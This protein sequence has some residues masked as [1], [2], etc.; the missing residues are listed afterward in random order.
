VKN[1][2]ILITG[3]AGFLGREIISRT[4]EDNEITV[5]SR[6]EAK[7]YYLKRHYPRVRFVVGDVRDFDRLK[8]ACD[9]HTTAI[10]AASLKQIEA[11]DENPQE[12]SRTIIDGA[13]NSRKA[14]ED[15]SLK[16][17]CFISSDK[18]RA[19]TTVYGAM[20]Y[21][22]GESFI[23][24]AQE[25]PTRLTT[26]IYGNVLNSTGS[27]IPLIW[28]AIKNRR[29][30]NLYSTE[31]TRFLLT[32]EEAVSLV[33]TSL[34]S[35]VTGVNIIPRAS[36]AKISDLFEIYA[37][38]FGLEYEVHQPRVG[39][40]IHEVMASEEETRRMRFSEELGFYIMDPKREFRELS[41]P[42]DV[43]SSRDVCVPKEELNELLKHHNHYK[44]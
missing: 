40:K 13:F 14:A 44:A 21:V 26:A 35:Q 28:N 36:S 10:F 25:S 5:F 6:D 32:V 29:S 3:G 16:S 4:Y 20:K 39:E 30:L 33:L 2:R 19:A 43:Y 8:R 17:A 1:E 41:F 9:G 15:C 31:M 12:A 37:E 23:L 38:L 22:A 34:E 18:S 42:N 24:H 11:C 27:V 7:H